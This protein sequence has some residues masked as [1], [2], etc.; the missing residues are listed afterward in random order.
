MAGIHKK[1]NSVSRKT[2][3]KNK[4]IIIETLYCK[5]KSKNHDFRRGSL[6]M[7]HFYS[8]YTVVG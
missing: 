1:E 4:M 6:G 5:P 8:V 2:D 3:T 7:M